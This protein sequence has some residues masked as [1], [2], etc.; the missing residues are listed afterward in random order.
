MTVH[1]QIDDK[2]A[3]TTD[4]YAWHIAK[5]TKGKDKDGNHFDRWEP[6]RHYPTLEALLK[7]HVEQRIRDSNA[8]TYAEVLLARDNALSRLTEALRPYNYKVS[9]K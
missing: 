1:I 3:I 2:T 7:A 6:I 9:V 5:K 4:T 8:Q